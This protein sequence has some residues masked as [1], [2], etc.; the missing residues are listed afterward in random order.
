VEGR[1]DE[2]QSRSVPG[3]G[4]GAVEMESVR[5]RAGGGDVLI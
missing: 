1:Q 2:A 4:L 3:G 5:R